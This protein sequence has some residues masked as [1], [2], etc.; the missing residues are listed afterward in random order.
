MIKDSLLIKNGRVIDPASRT[1]GI[2]DILCCGNRI[3]SV[4][5]GINEKASKVID[6]SGCIVMP[7]LVDMHVHLREPGREDKESVSSG[8]A[9]AARGGVTSVLAM[10]NT[11]PAIDS[12]EN[13]AL[14]KK[15]IRCGARVNVFISS[16]IT[17]E[18]QGK[19]LV[20][21]DLLKKSGAAAFSDDGC[22]VDSGEL[23]LKALV[24]S[25]DKGFLII[26]HCE[27]RKLSAGGAVNLG[28]VSTRMGLK[29]ISAES[30]YR[31][32]ERD[33]SLAAKARARVHI[34]HVSCAESV[35]IIARAKKKG[36]R[37]TAETAP[38][39][40]SLTEEA[41]L[42]YDTNMKMNPPLRRR[43]DLEAVKRGLREGIIDAIASDHAPHTENEKE[44]EFH[45]AE[46][47]V[48]GLETELSVAVTELINGGVLD[49]RGLAEK[50]S[51]NPSSILGIK[52]GTLSEGADADA[53]IFSP[54]E[55]WVVNAEDFASK[56]RN[57]SFLGKK[58]QG[59]VRYTVCS[60]K[61]IYAA[62]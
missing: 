48:T 44:V 43:E 39:Y 4:D 20:A 18:R 56:S 59:R 23:L 42:G 40:F 51:L 22:S 35:E 5:S 34:A 33:I 2:K 36:I 49:W 24:K 17:R 1:D 19:E 50:M 57:S 15:I 6:A 47:G 55:E 27:D 45:L 46:F 3:I 30:E 58:L 38:H 28:P 52:K 37:V 25:R 9:A 62:E 29:G 53:V 41:V 11:E 7:G 14:L 31:R 26:C 12:A 32:V 16:A 54:R 13:V 21:F 61:V 60:G 10:P 8:T